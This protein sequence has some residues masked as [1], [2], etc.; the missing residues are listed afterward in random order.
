M[1]PRLVLA[2]SAVLL[3][4]T[5]ADAQPVADFYR[6]KTI[7]L[8][9]GF[10]AGGNYD[11]SS[12]ILA[13]HI[14]RHIPGNPNVVPQNM[15]GAGSLRLANFLYNV[16]PKDGTTFGMVGRGISLEPLLG[17]QASKFEFAALHLDW[18]RQQRDFRV[19]ILA[20]FPDQKLERLSLDAVHCRRARPRL[21]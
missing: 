3:V 11:L 4:A 2:L 7:Q 12:R 17:T 14:G 18:Q 19:R 8:L 1:I 20:H 21:R 15:T 13:R 9:I 16:A 6:G 5:P 10:S